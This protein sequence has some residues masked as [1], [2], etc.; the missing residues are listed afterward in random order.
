MKRL[1]Y[2]AAGPGDMIAAHRF[3]QKQE[4]DPNIV[5]ITFSSQIAQF[6]KDRNFQ[7]LMI[8]P[9]GDGQVLDDGAFTIEHWHKRDRSGLGYHLEQIRYGLR[10][11]ARAIRFRADVAVLDLQCTHSFMMTLFR[12]F[13]IRVV[14]V[15]HTTLWPAAQQDGAAANA[16]LLQIDKMLFWTVAPHAMI[17]LSDECVRQVAVLAP[18]AKY[19]RQRALA[20]FNPEYFASVEPADTASKPF[21]VLFV[22][23]AVQSK[24]LLDLPLIAALVERRCPGDVFWTVCGDGPDLGRL[25]DELGQAGVQHLFEV[26]GW[27]KPADLVPFLS[28][29]HAVIVP[30]RAE[31]SEGMAMTAI[32]AVCAGRPVVTSSA[33]PALELLRPACLEVQPNDIEG[34]ADAV[35][36]LATDKALYD[37]LRIACTPLASQFFDRRLGLAAA[38][39]AVLE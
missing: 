20:Q 37:S 26:V 14:I 2:A 34:Y 12:L 9:Q 33:V 24:G 5:S 18:H 39:E 29:S 4:P 10:L 21:H 28:R 36:R 31:V 27:T 23:R 25:K 32:E 17:G 6:C 11:L 16:T 38:L 3:W 15:L 13:G 8:C 22:G 7:C 1:F 30:T 35:R 19:P